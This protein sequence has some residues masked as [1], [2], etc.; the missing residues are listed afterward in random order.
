MLVLNVLMALSAI[1]IGVVFWLLKND[2]EKDQD[3]NS[4]ESKPEAA[5][6][7]TEPSAES[8]TE[9]PAKPPTESPPKSKPLSILSSLKKKSAGLDLKSK[10]PLGLLKG[11]LSKI[12]F[13][14][15]KSSEMDAETTPMPNLKEYLAPE[16]KNTGEAIQE[17]SIASDK[18][19]PPDETSIKIILP[20]APEEKA[21]ISKEE[22]ENIGKEIELSSNLSE[23]KEKYDK[24][25]ALFSE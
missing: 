9:P 15:K 14:K 6:A 5:Q 7:T 19:A 17:Q 4:P 2:P 1:G 10:L 18:Q 11:A 8:P 16:N 23:L 3:N 12:K 21:T 13:G 24:L 22:E 25:E 20:E